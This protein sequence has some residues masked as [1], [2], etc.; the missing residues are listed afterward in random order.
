MGR[1]II[2][3]EGAGNGDQKEYRTG[4]LKDAGN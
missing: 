3:H 4:G 2:E 1:E